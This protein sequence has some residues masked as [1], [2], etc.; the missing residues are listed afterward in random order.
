[1]V[2]MLATKV[3]CP[4]C[5][6]KLKTP[7]PVPQ[8][9]HLRCSRCGHS[10]TVRVEDMLNPT[11]G[12]EAAAG[13][14]SSSEIQT[15]EEIAPAWEA[16]AP[17]TPVATMVSSTLS[18]QSAPMAARAAVPPPRVAPRRDRF[19]WVLPVLIV[20]GLVVIT[21]IAVALTLSLGGLGEP[22]QTTADGDPITVIPEPRLNPPV[23][24]LP[25]IPEPSPPE[26]PPPSPLDSLPPEERDRVKKAIERGVAFLRKS[27]HP[28]GA[29]P[30]GPT[31]G[32]AALPGLTLLECGVPAGD[33]LV[34]KAAACVRSGAPK[35]G[36]TY[37]IAL[38][39]L[40]LDRLGDPADEKLIQS[41]ALRLIA[42]QTPAGGWY[43]GC[44]PLSKDEEDKL[45]GALKD[46]RPRSTDDLFV[47]GGDGKRP[48][49]FF[50][51]PD[52]G[53]SPKPPVDHP[54]II[55]GLP[56][57][58]QG[59]PAL[60]VPVPG[61]AFPTSDTSDN[62]NTQFAALGLWV[63]GR[64]GIPIDRPLALLATRFRTSQASDG[65]WNYSY[66][67]QGGSTSAM[68]GAGLLGL[69]LGHG[70]VANHTAPTAEPANDPAMR[71]VVDP[72][73]TKGLAAI[74]SYIDDLEDKTGRKSGGRHINL[75]FLWTLERVAMLYNLPRIEGKDW[76]RW[77]A[78]RLVDAQAKKGNWETGGYPGSGPVLDTCLALLFL[79]RAN[80]ARD[81]TRKIEHLGRVRD[82]D[83]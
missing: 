77:G 63:A 45:L 29:W 33:S 11:G 1:M 12:T 17:D 22:Q 37:E 36:Q 20:S 80:V 74:A 55:A 35:L 82:K 5:S 34:Q 40:F 68:T 53:G 62:S 6:R 78:N 79:Q 7:R 69:A 49:W 66:N 28:T 71:T 51:V 70:L 27:Q 76:F 75:Y 61:K 50:R 8:G 3:S 67:R 10:F 24:S 56:R 18:A 73:L 30:G 54:R 2:F 81:L 21:V 25:P 60:Q 15:P 58:L 38:A 44:Q 72:A 9:K 39:I 59:I 26:P 14:L 46:T 43:Y 52:Q 42:G 13:R 65:G 16:T 64:H 41:L 83:R 31:I 32:L 4:N 47:A 48:D 19:R 23:K 57:N